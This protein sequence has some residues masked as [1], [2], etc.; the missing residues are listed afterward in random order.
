MKRIITLSLIMCSIL[1][2]ACN[3]KSS[4]GVIGGADGPTKIVVGENAGKI[5]GQF[6]EQLEKKEIRMF[7]V[8]GDL[9]Y[10]SGLISENTPRCGTMDGE[11]KKAVKENEI[12]LKSGE[13]NFEIEGYQNATSTTK[14]VNIGGQWLIFKKYDLYD[15]TIDNFKYCYYIKGHLNNAAIDSEMIVLSDYT[16]VTFNDI[17][18][19]L[20]SSQYPAESAKGAIHFNYFSKDKW[21]ITLYAED[22]TPKGMTLKIEQFGGN[23]SGTLQYGAAYTLETTVNDAWISVKTVNKEPLV[24]NAV[25][26]MVKMNDVTEININWEYGYGELKPGYYRLKKEF[27]DFRAPGDYDTETYEVYFTIE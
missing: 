2:T 5:K 12:P 16:D 20:L 13:A 23:A 22:V 9:Y 19:S 15:R 24:W 21:G 8:D 10:D 27:D 3:D 26:Y 7:N 17:H 18:D 4:I 11:L 1:L 6:G 14:E 25:A